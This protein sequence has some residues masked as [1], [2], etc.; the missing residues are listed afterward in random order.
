MIRFNDT[1]YSYRPGL[2]LREL[3]EDHFSELSTVVFDLFVIV[4]N[5]KAINSALAEEQ[6]LQDND[7]VYVVPK[8]DGG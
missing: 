5:Q 1:E 8:V 7:V 3:A 6:V 4:V 2:S